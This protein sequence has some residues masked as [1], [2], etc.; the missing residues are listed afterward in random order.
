MVTIFCIGAHKGH[1]SYRQK[2]TLII[3]IKPALAE[4]LQRYD[5]Y[6]LLIRYNNDADIKKEPSAD[7]ILLVTISILIT[8]L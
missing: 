1:L 7:W 3:T 6:V 2:I 4:L 8:Y 5:V